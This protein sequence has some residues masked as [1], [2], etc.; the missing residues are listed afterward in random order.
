MKKNLQ[1]LR[2]SETQYEAIQISIEDSSDQ[3]PY[4]TRNHDPLRSTKSELFAIPQLI[5]SIDSQNRREKGDINH[6]D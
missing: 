4:N 5:Q 3:Q 1:S 2:Y 6:E